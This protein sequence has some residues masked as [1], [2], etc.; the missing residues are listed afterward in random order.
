MVAQL[1]KR[2]RGVPDRLLHARRRQATLASLLARRPPQH[3]LAVCNGNIF[4]SPFTAAVLRRA[5]GS[6]GVGVDSAGFLGPG[7]PAPPDAVA[8]AASHGVDLSPHRSRLLTGDLARWA[9]L[10][11]VMDERQRQMVCDR[12][13]RARR[14]VV[15]LG[16]LD[17]QPVTSRGIEDPVE[18][19]VEVCRRAYARIERCVTELVNALWGGATGAAA[20]DVTAGRRR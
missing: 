4:R 17:P 10:V 1:L 8:A 6:R 13:G 12:F 18:Q 19:S 11:L 20:G 9:D 2:L 14:D 7:R 5:V 3:V 16:D 15:I